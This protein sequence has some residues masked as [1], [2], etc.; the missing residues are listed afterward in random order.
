MVAFRQDQRICRYDNIGQLVQYCRYSANPVGR[1]ILYLG[2]C[3]TPERGQLA[4]SICTGL[5]LANFWQDVARDAEMGRVYMPAA[6]RAVSATMMRCSPSGSLTS[7][8]AA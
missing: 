4:D 2:K 5:Q 8:F 3:H 7:P 6:D 1:L